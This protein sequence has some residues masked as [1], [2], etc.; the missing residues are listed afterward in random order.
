MILLEIIGL[1][2]AGKHRHGKLSAVSVSYAYATQDIPGTW[3][4][5]CPSCILF[6]VFFK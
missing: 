6:Y 5:W 3:L 1:L 2:R 4:H